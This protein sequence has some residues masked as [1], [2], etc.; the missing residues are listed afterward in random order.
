MFK[1]YEYEKILYKEYGTIGLYIK[2]FRYKAIFLFIRYN[3]LY[4]ILFE[5]RICL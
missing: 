4:I 5:V 2:Q 3:S 1:H